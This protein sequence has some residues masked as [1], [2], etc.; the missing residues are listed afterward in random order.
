MHPYIVT[1]HSRRYSARYASHDYAFDCEK[2]R[3][4]KQKRCK[5]VS[6]VRAR[7]VH[8]VHSQGT[9]WLR[10]RKHVHRKDAPLIA[11]NRSRSFWIAP[12]ELNEF[13]TGHTLLR[14]H[15]TFVTTRTAGYAHSHSPSSFSLPFRSEA[16]FIVGRIEDKRS[17]APVHDQSRNIVYMFYMLSIFRW[18]EKYYPRR[19]FKL[20]VTYSSYLKHWNL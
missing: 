8:S 18:M 2:C 3:K 9:L 17:D 10:Y 11:R 15:Y 12:T 1:L 19:I 13:T 6:P 16:C 7:T 4:R 14:G 20:I 5:K